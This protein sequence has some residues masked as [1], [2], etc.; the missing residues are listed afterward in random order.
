TTTTSWPCSSGRAWRSSRSPSRTCS[1]TS[2]ASATGW[3]RHERAGPAAARRLGPLL[4]GRQLRPSDV[5]DVGGRPDGGAD[6]EAPPARLPAPR[7]PEQRPPDLLQGPRVAAVLRD[8]QGRGGDLRRGA[9]LVPE[10][11]V[12]V[13]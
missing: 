2:R 12:E 9:A 3:L 7:E 5:L 13:R 11:R 6:G 10:V 8:A 1:P 4:C